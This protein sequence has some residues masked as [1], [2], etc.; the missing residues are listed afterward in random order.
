MAVF[1][2]FSKRQKKLRGDMP[3]VYVYDVLPNSLRVQ[4]VQILDDAIGGAEEYG[5][6]YHPRHPRAFG[7]YKNIVEILCREYGTFFLPSTREHA[8]QGR[9]YRAELATFLL[10]E[11]DAERVLDAIE[12]ACHYIEWNATQAGNKNGD[13]DAITEL[14]IR[15]R[16]HGVGYE[17]DDRKLI[18]IDSE[19]LHAETVKPALR[20][21][22]D[23]PEYVGAQAE[24]LTAFEHYRHGRTKESLAESLKALESTMKGICKKR[25]WPVPPNATASKLVQILFDNDL[26][27]KFWQQ[28]FAA[29]RSTLEAGV[30]T[31]RNKLGG[32]GQGV[33][34]LEVPEHVVSYVIY[35]TASAIVFL[36][37]AERE[38]P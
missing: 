2:L 17:Y 13:N 24:F 1:E 31:A 29:L 18:R 23:T 21:L 7:A 38:L 32:H 35:Q 20:L 37:A 27:P 8:F 6:R 9:D 11:V 33:E 16:E 28:H 36:D 25:N 22:R 4:M 12:L 26:V 34:V 15:F 14:N 10:N 30:P 19:L 3:D 5:N